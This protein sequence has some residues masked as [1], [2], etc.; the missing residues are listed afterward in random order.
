MIEGDTTVLSIDT[1][2]TSNTTT[3]RDTIRG[4]IGGKPLIAAHSHAHS[5]HTAGDATCSSCRCRS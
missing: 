2:A 1:G 5:D 3:L 4:L